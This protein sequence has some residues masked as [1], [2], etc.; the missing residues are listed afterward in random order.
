MEID[1]NLDENF[2][3]GVCLYCG[4]PLESGWKFCPICKAD[5]RKYKCINCG[6]EIHRKWNYCPYCRMD[7]HGIDIDKQCS[8]NANEWLRQILKG[9]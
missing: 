4:N 5:L 3:A 7:L 1:K 2:S 8:L 9:S 6:M